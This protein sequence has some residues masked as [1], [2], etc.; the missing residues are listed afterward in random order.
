MTGQR[1]GYIRVSSTGQNTER[2]L[3]GVRVDRI[4]EDKA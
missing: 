4:F 1:V 2:Q 3:E